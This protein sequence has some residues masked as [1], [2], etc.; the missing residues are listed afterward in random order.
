M[1]GDLTEKASKARVRYTDVPEGTS[2]GP[3]ERV[4]GAEQEHLTEF[5]RNNY[6]LFVEV[7]NKYVQQL[8]EKAFPSTEPKV[9][10]SVP[11]APEGGMAVTAPEFAPTGPPKPAP[12]MTPGRRRADTARSARRA[13][14]A[15]TSGG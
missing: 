14:S 12:E 13:A 5:V 6:D 1:T 11:P 10:P 4:S 15:N 3:R 7:A 2:M 8:Q 9:P